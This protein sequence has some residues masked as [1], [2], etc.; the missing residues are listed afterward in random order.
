MA[1][2]EEIIKQ[3]LEFVYG[4]R[5]HD[6]LDDPDKVS[7]RPSKAKYVDPDA[8][9]R[10]EGEHDFLAPSFPCAVYLPEEATPYPSFEHALLASKFKTQEKRQEVRET[11]LVRDVKRLISKEKNR[12]ATIH[13]DWTDRCLVIAEGLLIDKFMRNR[14]LKEQLMKTGRRSLTFTNDFS[15]LF[16]GVDEQQKGQ[17]NLGK[18]LEKVRMYIDQGDDLDM[19]LKSQVKLLEAEK[20]RLQMTV[21]KEGVRVE[22]DCQDFEL[23]SK[24]L[25]GK[26]DEMCDIVAAHPTISRV[27]AVLLATKSA[28]QPLVL[29]D[30][31]S[32]NGTKL[33]SQPIAAYSI[34]PVVPG[35]ILTFGAS[36]RQY[37]FAV[38]TAADVKRRAELLTKIAAEP[39]GVAGGIGSKENAENTVFV[40]NIS[41][42]ATEKDVEV[43][44]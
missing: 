36:S 34:T 21:S 4:K 13:A 6:K 1:T 2:K 32:A 25:I 17:N 11:P 28:D 5:T 15:D 44:Q 19:W 30:L 7:Y 29:V 27:H 8:I 20:A 38:D 22:E 24:F 42:D 23:R 10:F 41:F 43:G 39:V 35:S 40:G 26:S 16:W 12:P 18:L 14:K 9:T 31:G 3:N 33:N 37:S